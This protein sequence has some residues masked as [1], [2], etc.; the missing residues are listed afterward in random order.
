MK[1]SNLVFT[2]SERF[3]FF[4]FFYDWLGEC[5]L[6]NPDVVSSA[7]FCTGGRDGNIML[8]DVRCSK[9]GKSGN[10]G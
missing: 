6:L 5:F 7:V 8:W 1:E 9:K 10:V 2:T 3:L 4:F